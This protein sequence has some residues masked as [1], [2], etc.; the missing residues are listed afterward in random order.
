VKALVTGASG[1]IG[2][3]VARA[4]LDNGVEVRALLRTGSAAN[5]PDP[6][7]LESFD[8]D[9]RDP[10]SVRAAAE[11]CAAIF[12][13]GALY[14]FS[15][16]ADDLRATNIGGTRNVIDAAR[17]TGARLIYTSSI[18]TIGGMKNG[19]IPDENQH[20]EGAA[21]GP[22]KDSKWHAELMVSEEV[23]R[24]LDAVIVNPTFPVGW[25][26]VKPTP[27]GAMIRDFLRGKLPAYVD[28]GMNVVDVDDVAIG[29]LLAW[30]RGERGERYIL[31]HVNLMMRE[32]LELVA[33]IAGREPP[34]IRL[35]FAVVLGLAHAGRLFRRARVPLEAVRTAMEIRFATSA[36]AVR[37]LGLPQ[38]DVR[39]ALGKAVQWFE[40]MERNEPT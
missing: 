5:V 1:F 2:G 16:N 40:R 34:R 8:G 30:Q 26:D 39:A 6:S 23:R 32:L 4:L 11:G 20:A 33:E 12:H 10:R 19:V 7:A 31:G 18:S 17:A 37:E 22:Y 35:P 27:T 28:T 13:V 38:T 24:G 21:P 15:A 9:L 25:G 3:A 36:R 29:H 14:S